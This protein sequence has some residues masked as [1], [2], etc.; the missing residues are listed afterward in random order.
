MGGVEVARRAGG[1]RS[2]VVAMVLDAIGLDDKA[3]DAQGDDERS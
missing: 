1:Q 2:E 3:R